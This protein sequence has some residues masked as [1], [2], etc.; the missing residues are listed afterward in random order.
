MEGVGAEEGDGTGGEDGDERGEEGGGLRVV[1]RRRLRV[2]AICQG[3]GRIV[4][5]RRAGD[6][7]FPCGRLC[8]ELVNKIVPVGTVEGIE[9]PR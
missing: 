4:I 1:T 8:A 5:F 9:R 2:R 7:S 6:I 3:W